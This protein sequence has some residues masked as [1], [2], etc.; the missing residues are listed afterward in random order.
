VIL[1]QNAPALASPAL[2]RT[3]PRRMISA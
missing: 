2:Q 3:S 1:Y